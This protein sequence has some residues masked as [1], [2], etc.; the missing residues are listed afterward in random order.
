MLSWKLLKSWVLKNV[1]PWL[2]I[3]HLICKVPGTSNMQGAWKIIEDKFP[4]IFAN[5]CGAHVMNLLIKDICEL[6]RYASI[7]SRVQFVVKFIKERQHILAM[8]K[9]L[10]KQFS[11]S[12]GLTLTVPTRWYTHYNSCF[13]LLKAKFAVSSLIEE[14][15][16]LNSIRSQEP[17][18][19]FKQIIGDAS[20]WVGL[21]DI[22]KILSFP[23][24]IIGK[25]ESDKS[26]L[27]AV[28]DYFKRLNDSFDNIE[29]IDDG[30]AVELKEIVST[31]WNFIHTESMGF[32]YLLSPKSGNKQWVSQDKVATKKQLKNYISVF[33]SDEDDIKKCN[34]ELTNY[35]T[36]MGNLSECLEEEYFS[37]SGLQ[38]WSQYGKADYPLLGKI[39]LRLFTIPT[40]SAASERVWSIYSFIHSKRR[41]RLGLEKVEKLVFIYINN[42]LL[43]PVDSIDYIADDENEEED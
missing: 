8:F 33:Y 6:D 34:I 9:D 4:H 30:M 19:K 20:F 14:E 23:T 15:N 1:Y 38:Y 3:T 42:C 43:D 25:F 40:S 21:K 11:I 27:F 18:I 39:A 13:N 24:A 35:L 29:G 41:N 12:H 37:L 31:R 32:A 2:R 22:V 28:Y 10:R 17:V 7:L 16:L 26:D 36:D 5:G